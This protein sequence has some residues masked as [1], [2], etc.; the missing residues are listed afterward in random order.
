[1]DSFS[2]FPTTDPDSDSA[3]GIGIG[4]EASASIG[5]RFDVSFL[6]ILNSSNPP[7][8]GVEYRFTDQLELQSASNLEN[9]DF[10]LE[11]RIRF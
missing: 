2:V 3:V 9:T 6:D 5:N 4:V 11:Y 7:R 8:L 10:K 1:L